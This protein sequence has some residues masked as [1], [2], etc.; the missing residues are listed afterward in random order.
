[1]HSAKKL[2]KRERREWKPIIFDRDGNEI[3]EQEHFS[4]SRY[5]LIAVKLLGYTHAEAGFRKLGEISDEFAEYNDMM[6]ESL[7]NSSDNIYE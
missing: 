1:M 2:N 4:H 5:R 3:E 6:S 7:E